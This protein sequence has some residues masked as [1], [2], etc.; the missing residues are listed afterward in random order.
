MKK[1]GLGVECESRALGRREIPGRLR[2]RVKKGTEVSAKGR[3]AP[4]RS[5][6]VC[7]NG[8]EVVVYPGETDTG[9][10][11]LPWQCGLLRLLW[12]RSASTELS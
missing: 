9:I 5:N 6:R 8:E 11:C 12:C 7:C 2:K 1:D 3:V 4:R 10:K